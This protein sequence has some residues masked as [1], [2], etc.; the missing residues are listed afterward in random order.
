MDRADSYRSFSKVILRVLVF[1]LDKVF[2]SVLPLGLYTAVHWSRILFHIIGQQKQQ[3][4][5]CSCTYF[6]TSQNW[7]RILHIP[8]WFFGTKIMTLKTQHTLNSFFLP[9]GW[10][11]MWN[12]RLVNTSC[13]HKLKT[14]LNF[15]LGQ[16]REKSNSFSLLLCGFFYMGRY[17]TP[18][19][20]HL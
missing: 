19:S 18:K 14:K 11:F 4:N 10:F 5:C 9:V 17:Y 7:R 13:R 6:G 12:E 2:Q 15:L 16:I 8:W 3:K 1:L 20:G